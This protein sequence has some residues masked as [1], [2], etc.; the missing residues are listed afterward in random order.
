MVIDPTE[1][2]YHLTAFNSGISRLLEKDLKWKSTTTVEEADFIVY[3]GGAD[4]GSEYYG[5]ADI[6]GKASVWQQNRDAR[7]FKI[8]RDAHKGQKHIGICRGAQLLNVANG[9][10]LWQDVDNHQTT[11][12]WTIDLETNRTVLLNSR[13]HQAM[14]PSRDGVVLAVANASTKLTKDDGVFSAEKEWKGVWCDI[15]AVIYSTDVLCFQAHPEDCTNTA[16][17]FKELLTR[18][19]FL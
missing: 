7:E 18:K 13:H 19:G 8:F 16:T 11:R 17:Y 2:T 12:H 15:E 1:K 14:I 4:I 6:Q 5:Q 3:P 10:S 9:G